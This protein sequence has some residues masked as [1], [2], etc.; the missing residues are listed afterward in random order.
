MKGRVMERS[1]IATLPDIN[2]DK[3]DIIGLADDPPTWLTTKG[4]SLLA[5]QL[6]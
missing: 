3:P 1:G 6:A 4:L 2:T 5:L